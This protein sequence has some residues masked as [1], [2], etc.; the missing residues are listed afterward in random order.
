MSASDIDESKAGQALKLIGEF[1]SISLRRHRVVGN[2]ARYDDGARNL[3]KDIRD[4]IVSGLHTNTRGQ[5]NYLIWGPSGSGKTTFIKELGKS[6]DDFACFKELNLADLNE[7]CF[8]EGLAQLERVRRPLLCFIDEIDSKPS[9]TW[10]YEALL[11]Q[12]EPPTPRASRTCFV[13]AGSGE[14]GISELKE[15]IGL[16]PKGKDL[17]T[18][19]PFKNQYEVPPMDLSDK[20]L[21]AVCH[22][23]E[24]A[25]KLHFE[26]HWVEKLALLYIA[27]NPRLVSL[28]NV[29][30]LALSCIGRIPREQDRV[31]YDHLF[32]PGDL[33]SKEFWQKW[34]DKGLVGSFTLVEDDQAQ[35]L[36]ERD[37]E[38]TGAER[39]LTKEQITEK[40]ASIERSLKE[41]LNEPKKVVLVDNNSKIARYRT[42]L[43]IF[44]RDFVRGKLEEHYGGEWWRKGVPEG[45]Q[46]KCDERRQLSLKRRDAAKDER[47]INFADF[48]D[49]KEIFLVE[50]NWH[51]VFRKYYGEDRKHKNTIERFFLELY[52]VRNDECHSRKIPDDD[53]R[54]FV[55]YSQEL[56]CIAEQKDEFKKLVDSLEIL[57]PERK[58]PMFE[59]VETWVASARA[60]PRKE[61]FDEGLV[62]SDE[63]TKKAILNMLE[64]KRYCLLYGA[65]ASRKTT[66]SLAFGLDLLKE[67][68]VVL[69]F[70]IR[71]EQDIER[72]NLIDEIRSQDFDKLLYIIDDC[73]KSTRS[74][75]GL[76]Q[77]VA[78]ETKNAK[79]LFISRKVSTIDPD[80]DYFKEFVLREAAFELQPMDQ[81][82]KGIIEQ[83]C[84]SKQIE[85]YT[86]MIGDIKAIM[87][88]CGN[89][90]LFLNYLLLTWREILETKRGQILSS[91]TKERFY[92]KIS[93]K[94]VLAENRDIFKLCALYQFEIPI[95]CDFAL[96][97]A[98]SDKIKKWLEEG[99][100]F[101]ESRL[102]NYSMP[103]SS[104]A[105]VFLRAGETR[106]LLMFEG[107]CSSRSLEEYSIE[108]LARY[109][110][111]KAVD[112][113]RVISNVYRDEEI[114][115]TNELLRNAVVLRA[116]KNFFDSESDINFKINFLVFL[117]HRE[118]DEHT[119]KEVLRSLDLGKLAEQINHLS[120]IQF[121]QL[122]NLLNMIEERQK[123]LV[124]KIDFQKLAEEIS[125]SPPSRFQ[126]I[127]NLLK[128]LGSENAR[129]LS[130]LNCDK[131]AQCANETSQ[132]DFRGLTLLMAGLDEEH[133]SKI[134][135]KIDWASL[136]IKCPID[137]GLLRAL[138]IL[139][140]NLWKQAE[141]LGDTSGEEKV[142]EYLQNRESDVMEAIEN[143]HKEIRNYLK[144]HTLVQSNEKRARRAATMY[145]GLGKFLY[146]W[147]QI[148]YDSAF[149]MITG[150]MDELIE[151]FEVFPIAY[152][153]IGQLVNAFHRLDPSLSYSF[154]TD[155]T[156]RGR[157]Q[158]S[159]NN[160]DWRANAEG[161]EH[162][163]EA[164][165]RSAPVL[166][167]KMVNYKW[168]SVDLDF[169]DL[170][171]VYRR[172]DEDK[173]EY[174]E[175][176]EER[177][178]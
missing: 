110:H 100:I 34:K 82:F 109:L 21:V 44:L 8:R 92:D 144:T 40:V 35:K 61:H 41:I 29:S 142:A 80:Y 89:N 124:E 146:H 72:L 164:F 98:P 112:L 52:R 58:K 118:I 156:I 114:R 48:L 63:K 152:Y 136:C 90:I 85:N 134:I 113:P 130:L 168:I 26:I 2:Y 141:M 36:L 128:A 84:V 153:Y 46:R 71:E 5:E 140:E 131:L 33:D 23:T 99:L 159:I 73:H 126:D 138:G 176:Y 121:Q 174:E 18:R 95:S 66:F 117:G 67:G 24:E 86:E 151:C 147:A 125:N 81:A 150:T 4:K 91:I 122:T 10:P 12:L 97:Q 11:P 14:L 25:R 55:V 101:E 102:P 13:L 167:R 43:E 19:I 49:I 103:H 120:Y 74:I 45:V 22:F 158:W 88:I 27:L 143:A 16:H 127:A 106:R 119:K 3:L 15:R 54:K 171:S 132:S 1:D 148:D 65:P 30:Q 104:L 38:V 160:H 57:P 108:I 177:V 166:W 59:N 133:R 172:V 37:I 39:R 17:L 64:S 145:A 170:D 165:Y 115:I 56:L 42:F 137:A 87:K 68:Y 107:D 9:E 135:E 111:I 94:Y 96:S 149:N 162:L 154:L 76:V 31:K 20:I 93:K 83:F 123:E 78:K 70:G 69:Y 79:F 173:T 53:V 47:L 163:I 50:K 178:F 105:R 155:N 75:H 60:F 175:E 161:L 139:L 62:Y 169:L 32:D 6:I 51:D 129:L 116:I 77:Q 157:I 28:R 7:I